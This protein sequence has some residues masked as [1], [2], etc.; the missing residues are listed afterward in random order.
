MKTFNFLPE[1]WSN[2]TINIKDTNE[3]NEYIQN[4][5]VLQGI[6]EECDDTF[7]LHINLGAGISGVMPRNEIEWINLENDGTPKKNLC[8]GKVHKYIQ[9]KVKGVTENNNII[10]SRKDV[11]KE[12]LEQ[13]MGNLNE[14]D[15]VNG[16]VKNITP[17][18]A[19]VE[20]GGE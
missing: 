10:L 13:A 7:N 5:Q 19:F 11:Q 1:G 4:G 2:E 18:G 6:V 16:I 15:K 9:F 17:Y 12:A 14:G 3:I 20:I 8:V